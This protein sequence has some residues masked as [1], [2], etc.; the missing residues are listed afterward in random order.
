MGRINNQFRAISLSYRLRGIVQ[1]TQINKYRSHCDLF[2]VLL[3]DLIFLMQTERQYRKTR[4]LPY[5]EASRS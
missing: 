1:R 4:R 3:T 5:K 2:Q